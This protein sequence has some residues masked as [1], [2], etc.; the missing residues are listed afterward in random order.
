M[1]LHGI[2]AWYHCMVGEEGSWA[3]V[4]YDGM[5]ILTMRLVEGFLG[6]PFVLLH[7]ALEI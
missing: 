6:D 7:G 5:A 3:T 2:T 4:L 1:A